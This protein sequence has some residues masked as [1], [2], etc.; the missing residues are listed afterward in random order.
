MED[1]EPIPVQ[2]VV[3]SSRAAVPFS[4]KDPVSIVS[5][6]RRNNEVRDIN[7]MGFET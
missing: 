2:Y 6:Q 3:Y 7:G 5:L 4:Q 1:I